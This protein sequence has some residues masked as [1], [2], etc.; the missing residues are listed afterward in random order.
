MTE[1]KLIKARAK[2]M[3]G[4]VGMASML[5]NLDL[6]ED[7]SF[8]T[9]AT[10]GQKFIGIKILLKVFLKRNYKQYWYTKLATLYGNIH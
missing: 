8:D 6:V 4:N 7:S 10:D 9:L 5:L 2:L 1:Q 3:K